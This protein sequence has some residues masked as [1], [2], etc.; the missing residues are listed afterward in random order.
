M[1]VKNYCLDISLFYVFVTLCFL[2]TSFL[3]I[4]IFALATNYCP[5]CQTAYP[6]PPPS[7]ENPTAHFSMICQHPICLYLCVCMFVKNQLNQ[8]KDKIYCYNSSIKLLTCP[9]HFFVDSLSCAYMISTK[10][11]SRFQIF[12]IFSIPF[13]TFQT[14]KDK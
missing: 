10:I 3:V 9:M 1:E 2:Y 4:Y 14:Q 13:H 8:S 6:P 5:N 11:L 12:V 7:I